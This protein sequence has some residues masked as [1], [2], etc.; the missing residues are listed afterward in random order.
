MMK[1]WK[2][3]DC[4][5]FNNIPRPRAFYIS[6]VGTNFF[7]NYLFVLKTFLILLNKNYWLKYR[8][9]DDILESNLFPLF[10]I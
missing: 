10:K 6:S 3:Y 8:L 4:R 2:N 9:F 7:M 1:C 5:F